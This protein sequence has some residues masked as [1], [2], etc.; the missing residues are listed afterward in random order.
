MHSYSLFLINDV[1]FLL[2]FIVMGG[3]NNL[4]NDKSLF[5]LELS[6]K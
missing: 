2:S 1:I 3:K 4:K 5:H 6:T